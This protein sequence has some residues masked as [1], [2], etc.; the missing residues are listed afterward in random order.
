[1][2]GGQGGFEERPA[3]ACRLMLTVQSRY[4]KPGDA[5][6]GQY[7]RWPGYA[8]DKDSCQSHQTITAAG[9]TLYCKS[10]SPSRCV[11]AA[12][13]SCCARNPACPVL[14]S[15]YDEKGLPRNASVCT[16]ALGCQ[17]QDRPNAAW[18]ASL[19]P[20][21][22]RF[23]CVLTIRPLLW[24]PP[25]SLCIFVVLFKIWLLSRRC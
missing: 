22:D 7:R 17:H 24:G 2:C 23:C 6:L 8:S 19:R 1:M 12:T 16:A 25:V 18:L 15:T 13:N 20:S 5:C 10:K 11:L 21:P 4:T 9:T 14:F 3:S